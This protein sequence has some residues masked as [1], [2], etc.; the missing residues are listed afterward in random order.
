MVKTRRAFIA[1]GCLGAAAVVLHPLELLGCGALA[2]EPA[3]G[4]CRSVD[5][6]QSARAAG[7]AYLEVSCSAWLVPGAAEDRFQRRLTRLNEAVLPAR[8]AN[9]FLPGSLKCVGPA[10]DH[11][12]VLEYAASAFVRA[13]RAGIGVITFGSGAARA[14]PKGFARADAQAQFEALLKKMAPLAAGHNVIVCIEPLQALETNFINRVSEAQAIVENVD[15]PNIA[16]TADIY[17]MLRE[18]EPAEAISKAGP[19]IRHIHI[20]E[21]RDRTPPG[22]DGD[23]FTPYLMALRDIDYQGLMSIECRWDDLSAQLPQAIKTLRAQINRLPA[24]DQPCGG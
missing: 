13:R 12:R 24:K 21:H 16:I 4:V 8:A 6:A 23:D 11:R 1:D 19:L 17:H 9:G 7:A 2:F 3:I 20:A 5:E 15:R 18:K 22:H 14:I 10:A